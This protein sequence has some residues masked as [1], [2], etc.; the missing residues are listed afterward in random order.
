METLYKCKSL[1]LY[2]SAAVSLSAC[3]GGFPFAQPLEIE[4]GNLLERDDIERIETGMSREQVERILGRPALK[5]PF[6]ENRWDYLYEHHGGK[7]EG[8]TSKRLT[9][10]FADGRVVDINDH[11]PED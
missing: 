1:L 5:H 9:L 7:M 8:Q 6:A 10:F 4:Q 2:I 11:W 3:G